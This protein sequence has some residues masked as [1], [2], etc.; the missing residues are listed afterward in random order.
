M[1][2]KLILITGGSSGIGKA[3]AKQLHKLGANI[4]IQSR[5]LDKLEK[6]SK[7]I[8]PNGDRIK[9]YSTDLTNQLEV[10]KSADEIIKNEGLPDVIIN[11]AGSG[12]W[13]SFK[14][15][16]NNHFKTTIESP[17][18]AAALTC[19]IFYDKMQKRSTGHFIIV[20]SVAAYFSFPGATGYAPARWALL[21]LVKSLQADFYGTNFTVSMVALGKVDSPYFRNN[22]TSESKI[23]KIATLLTPTLT[24][25]LAGN[26]I[27]KNVKSKKPILIK[28][29]SMATF[30]F[31]NRFFPKIFSWLVRIN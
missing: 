9:Y 23:P 25:N 26:Y 1:K 27:A 30:V 4:I 21:G 2:G 16:S 3:T 31:L 28:P 5:N 10:E 22:P 17:Y 8:S 14:E 6:A 18:L 11:S 12:E 19:K 15:A 20:N 24:E 13:L 29:F 7:E